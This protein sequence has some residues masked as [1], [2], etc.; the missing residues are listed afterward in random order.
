MG[1]LAPVHR[2]RARILPPKMVVYFVRIFG[3]MAHRDRPERW[4]QLAAV[5]RA[6][7]AGA[8]APGSTLAGVARHV[9]FQLFTDSTQQHLVEQGF[10]QNSPYPELARASLD[11]RVGG[12]GDHDCRH[13][14]AALSQFITRDR[15]EKAILRNQEDR[16]SLRHRLSSSG[17]EHTRLLAA[18]RS[19]AKVGLSDRKAYGSNQT[20]G[21]ERPRPI[22]HAVVQS[23]LKRIGAP[24]SR[25]LPL[26]LADETGAAHPVG[27]NPGDPADFGLDT[28]AREDHDQG[29]GRCMPTS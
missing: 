28:L 6:R 23:I 26:S 17:E 9:L 24:A 4:G 11:P 12:S 22:S 10:F 21:Q 20:G 13:V 16:W 8:P 27:G 18:H 2:F 3:E 5:D 19:L 7:G 14:V 25:R 29:E 15:G 1:G